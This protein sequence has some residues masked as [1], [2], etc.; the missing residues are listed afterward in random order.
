VVH[1][2]HAALWPVASGVEMGMVS[3]QKQLSIEEHFRV[4]AVCVA[5]TLTPTETAPE[6]SSFIDPAAAPGIMGIPD[7]RT[8]VLELE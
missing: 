1:I 5:V 7:A 4:A 6:N 3:V 2:I 8:R